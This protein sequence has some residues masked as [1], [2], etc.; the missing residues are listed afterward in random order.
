MYVFDTGASWQSHFLMSQG[1]WYRATHPQGLNSPE[2][3]VEGTQHEGGWALG[4]PGIG[5][6]QHPACGVGH[7]L[8]GSEW[9]NCGKHLDAGSLL[10]CFMKLSFHTLLWGWVLIEEG[11][12]PTYACQNP[13]SPEILCVYTTFSYGNLK[14]IM[15]WSMQRHWKKKL[16][17]INN[18]NP[19]K[20]ELPT[21]MGWQK[22][23][24]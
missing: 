24:A 20:T 23:L 22:C 18:N 12:L 8:L 14:V 1:S 15:F 6:K 19:N 16:L 21:C 2:R 3:R 13:V 7:K 10:L 4:E 5:T 11:F 9:P 17:M